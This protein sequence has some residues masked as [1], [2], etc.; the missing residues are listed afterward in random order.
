MDDLERKAEDALA[1]SMRSIGLSAWHM[2]T[3][4]DGFPDMLVSGSRIALIE[5]KYDRWGGR[6]LIKNIME[7][8]Q[9][10]FIQ[11]IRDSGFMDI[12]VCAYNG[13]AYTVYDTSHILALSINNS[14]LIA[15]K[16]LAIGCAKEIAVFF[17]SI[18]E[19]I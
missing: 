9:P 19:G 13:R 18:C 10:V 17:H 12:Y 8:T 11:G 2:N 4:I 14:E 6:G 15:M 7:P 16:S 1:K 3:T 5:M